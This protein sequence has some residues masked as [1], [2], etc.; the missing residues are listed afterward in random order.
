MRVTAFRIDQLLS[1]CMHYGYGCSGK[2]L[3]KPYDGHRERIGERC[4]RQKWEVKGAFKAIPAISFQLSPPLSFSLSRLSLSLSDSS[5]LSPLF[6]LDLYHSPAVL[7]HRRV[8]LLNT[9]KPSKPTLPSSYQTFPVLFSSLPTSIPSK[10][11]RLCSMSSEPT[12]TSSESVVFLSFESF[13]VCPVSLDSTFRY[14]INLGH[15]AQH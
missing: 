4:S 1:Y 15:I 7:H 2:T 12:P 3:R 6:A 14:C 11:G 8:T 10:E 5:T 13:S 9:N